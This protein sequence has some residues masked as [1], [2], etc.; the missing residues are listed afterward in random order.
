[1]GEAEA[2]A[3]S[4]SSS[5]DAL[6]LVIRI[7]SSEVNQVFQGVVAASDSDFVRRLEAFH[8]ATAAHIAYIRQEVS[9]LEPDLAA[10][11]QQMWDAFAAST[12]DKT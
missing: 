7:E 11:S 5:I 12:N 1:M 4:L 10:E 6:R 8:K 3:E 2:S 9:R